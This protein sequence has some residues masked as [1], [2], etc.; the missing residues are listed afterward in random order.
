MCIPH[1]NLKKK[2]NKQKNLMKKK[3]RCH[4]D[5]EILFN[6]M[7]SITMHWIKTIL[8]TSMSPCIRTAYTILIINM[9]KSKYKV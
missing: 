5:Y 8:S 7:T 3:Y 6:S 1:K 9:Y 4:T 2:I